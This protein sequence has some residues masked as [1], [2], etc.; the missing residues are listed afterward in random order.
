MEIRV[1]AFAGLRE[2][3][4]GPERDLELPTGARVRDAWAALAQRWPALDD[5][6]ASTRVARNGRIATFDDA[7]ADG[8]ELALLPPVGGG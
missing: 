5:L 8:D 2:L 3:L 4:E 6:R 1:L 7:L